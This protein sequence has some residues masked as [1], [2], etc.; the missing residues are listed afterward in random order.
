ML[1]AL[2]PLAVFC[3]C[4]APETGPEAVAYDYLHALAARDAI[5][6][7]ALLTP[8]TRTRLK[9]LH[10]QLLETRSLIQR[11]YPASK[12]KEA[13]AATGADVLRE[14]DTPEKLF[15]VLLERAG[16]RAE[17]HRLQQFGTRPREVA[18]GKNVTIV[19]T[20]GGD[21]VRLVAIGDGWFVA[22]GEQDASRLEKLEAMAERNL[23]RVRQVVTE[24][25]T[26]RFGGVD[27]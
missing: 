21:Q 8:E 7:Y 1:I 10:D 4:Q 12:R 13:M 19:T 20:W 6:V 26:K 25:R 23:A 16:T 17:L 5:K 14:A 9:R 15:V 2:I 22:L 27:R 11:Y 24:A 3:G 18:R